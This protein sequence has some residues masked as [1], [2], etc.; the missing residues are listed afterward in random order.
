MASIVSY[1]PE[2]RVLMAQVGSIDQLRKNDVIKI[3]GRWLVK[4]IT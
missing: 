4:L 1:I 2:H 3:M